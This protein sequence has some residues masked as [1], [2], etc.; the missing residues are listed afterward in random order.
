M[1]EV[2]AL[3]AVWRPRTTRLVAYITAGVIVLGLIVLAV[4]VA[5][6]FK[7]F[8]RILMVAFG[9]VIA[10]ILHMLA[11]CRV[12]ADEAGLTLVN[13]FRTRRLEWPEVVDVSM[14]VGEPWPTLDLADGTSVGAMGINGTEKDLAARQLAELK[15]LLHTR[16]EAP[17]PT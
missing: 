8:D 2:P 17:D 12:V 11:R 7:L 16:G 10:W 15:A 5:P 6:Q 13:A 1:T 4:V 9:G 3:P 14:S